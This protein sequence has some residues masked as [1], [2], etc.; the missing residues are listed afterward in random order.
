MILIE[1]LKSKAAQAKLIGALRF[2]LYGTAQ[3]GEAHRAKCQE[4]A[5]ENARLRTE[6]ALLTRQ[7]A[8]F[9]AG[10]TRRKNKEGGE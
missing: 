1:F 4:F 5:E 10:Q 8:G 6:N 7:L 2:S 9:K 3:A